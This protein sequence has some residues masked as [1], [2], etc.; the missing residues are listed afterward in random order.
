MNPQELKHTLSSGLLT[1]PVTDF[2]CCGQLP[3]RH[4]CPAAGLVNGV[5]PE[6]AVCRR[7]PWRILLAD[8]ARGCRRHPHR[9]RHLSRQDTHYRRSRRGYPNDDCPCAGSS[10]ARGARCT[11]AAALPGVTCLFVRYC[12]L[13]S[14]LL[15][16]SRAG[17][18]LRY[19]VQW[20]AVE[21]RGFGW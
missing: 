18:G 8:T 6:G 19:S 7:C 3:A 10:A 13:R 1:F 20:S 2:D 15:M 12:T 21:M 17:R 11:A 4:L 16:T 5:S 9:S 14:H